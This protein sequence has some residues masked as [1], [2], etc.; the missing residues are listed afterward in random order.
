MSSWAAVRGG[1]AWSWWAFVSRGVDVTRLDPRKRVDA[2]LPLAGGMSQ[3]AVAV[4]VGVASGTVGKWLKDPAFV[5]EL[6]R[7]RELAARKPLD[8][9]AVMAAVDEAAV[10]LGAGPVVVS[11]PAGA[12][13]RRRRQLLAGGIARALEASESG[14]GA[15]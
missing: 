15:R 7:I 9:E 4:E 8:V 12:S 11:I 10:R 2:L 1:T 6:G 3:R 5:R 14:G 13:P